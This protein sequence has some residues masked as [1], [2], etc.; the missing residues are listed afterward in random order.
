MSDNT[1]TRRGFLGLV[2]AAGATAA[3]AG[4]GGSS[5]SGKTEIEV[6]TYKQ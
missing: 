5:D 1:I 3:L 2:G 4:C 6:V